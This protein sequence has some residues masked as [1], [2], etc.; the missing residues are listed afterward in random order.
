VPDGTLVETAPAKINLTLRVLGR[1]ADGYHELE[2]L[3][4]FCDIAD[5]LSLQP[6]G[7]I[8]LDLAGPFA[9]ACGPS[10]GNLVLK[11]AAALGARIPG[12][13]LGRFQLEKK[14]PVAAGL[15]GGSADAAAALRLLARANAIAPGD[16]RLLA[17]AGDTGADVPVC[18]ELRA[19]VMRGVGD[20][21]SAPVDLPKLPALLVNPGV[22]LATRDVFAAFKM[23]ETESSPL[24]HIPHEPEA[25]IDLLAGES[26]D[27]TDAAVACAPA[28]AGV[29]AALNGLRGCR[30]ARMS[31]SGAS[32]FA[33][34][35]SGRDAV[36]AGE[37]LRAAHRD[38]WTC[39]ATIG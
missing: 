12:L 39:P 37:S 31:G 21:L 32:C 30:L 11:A 23:T 5:T 35:D 36:A 14:I 16:P 33:L 6:G 2:S 34:F 9:G 13:Q 24:D 38:W 4:A 20:R 25:L 19:R 1:H 27:L 29:L 8:T 26:N 15:G 22:A 18:L 10:A 7:S 3:V 17:A 28:V